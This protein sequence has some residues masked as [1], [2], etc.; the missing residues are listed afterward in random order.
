MQASTSGTSPILTL[1]V[2]ICL[3][4]AAFDFVYWLRGGTRTP[5]TVVR[6]FLFVL[7]LLVVAA[8]VMTFFI[9]GGA[10]GTLTGFFSNVLFTCWEYR[11]WRVRRA[12][13]LSA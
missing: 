12:N 10:A 7:I 9:G 6:S 2:L 5:P 11:R 1:L 4:A 8:G 3:I 13:P